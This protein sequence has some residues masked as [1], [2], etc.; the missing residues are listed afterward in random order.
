MGGVSFSLK[1]HSNSSI[2]IQYVCFYFISLIWLIS[3]IFGPI[4]IDENYF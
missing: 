4:H 2:L 3:Y 1:C